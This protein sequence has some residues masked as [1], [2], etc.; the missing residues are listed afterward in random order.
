MSDMHVLAGDGNR[1]RVVMHFGVPD[2]PNSAAVNWRIA[3]LNSGRGGATILPDG[4][5]PGQIAAAEKALIVN[6]EVVEHV[7]DFL[8]ESCGTDTAAQQAALRDMYD[9]ERT[10]KLADLQ[11]ELRYFGHV[12]SQS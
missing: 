9:Q 3:L 11:R 8:L 12:E 1:C 7:V 2:A 4:S 6:G 10:A 5:G